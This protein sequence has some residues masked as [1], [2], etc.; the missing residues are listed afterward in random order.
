M[1]RIVTGKMNSRKT[2][3]MQMLYENHPSGDGF[4][5]LKMML[6]DKVHSY[7]ALRLSTGEKFPLV[8]RDEFVYESFP[9]GCQIGPYLF[10]QKT[11]DFIQKEMLE[12]I[13]NKVQPLFLDEVGLLEIEGKCF[14]PIVRKM[15]DSRLDVCFSIREDLIEP[16]VKKY[17]VEKYEILTE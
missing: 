17:G 5:A 12:L 2:Q 8:V 7:Q 16:F 14:D 4:V 10:N 9:I 11:I 15:I 13:K 6:K 3:R 1:V